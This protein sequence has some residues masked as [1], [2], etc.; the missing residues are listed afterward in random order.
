M[1]K[2]NIILDWLHSLRTEGEFFRRGTYEPSTKVT[3]EFLDL[4]GRPDKC[5][6]QR[7]IVGGSAGKGSVCRMIYQTLVDHGFKVALISSP[8]LQVLTERIHINGKLGGYDNFIESISSIKKISDEH[9][10]TPTYYECLVLAGI[11]SAQKSDCEYLIAEIGCG[12]DFDAVNAI[13]GSRIAA[14][15]FIGHDHFELFG[16]DLCLTARA[17]AGIFDTSDLIKAYSFEQIYRS[18]LQKRSNINI[19][20][21]KGL[22]KKLN[23]KIA[24]KILNNFITKDYIISNPKT[25]C[26]W[27]TVSR[28]SQSKIILDG[29]HSVERFKF[30]IPKIKK[31]SGDKIL[32]CG[33]KDLHNAEALKLLSPY[34]DQIILT[35]N[36]TD[37]S[38]RKLLPV[39]ALKKVLPEACTASTPSLALEMAQKLGNHKANIIITGSL[40]LC[41]EIREEF[42]PAQ[43]ILEQQTEFPI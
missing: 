23:K 17:K 39:A 41:A 1:S 21:I 13:Q 36:K 29:A 31:L 15:T 26:R 38:S 2:I 25:P 27:E 24:R 19:E 42:Y 37:R 35:T 43:K 28:S 12:G 3:H 33:V 10:I 34:F 9:S 6:K 5:F 32:I 14:V 30:I 16:S 40:Y 20:F 4:M 18:E 11:L 7:V 22:N 8:H